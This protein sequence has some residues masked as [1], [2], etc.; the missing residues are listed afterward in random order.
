[1][2]FWDSAP[3]ANILP[4]LV[5]SGLIPSSVDTNDF[6][7]TPNYSN[8]KKPKSLLTGTKTLTR[9]TPNYQSKLSMQ[10]TTA[11]AKRS[12]DDIALASRRSLSSAT[13]VTLKPK[14]KPSPLTE[15]TQKNFQSNVVY[16]PPETESYYRKPAFKKAFC[17]KQ[18]S[19]EMLSNYDSMIDNIMKNEGDENDPRF[20]F[21]REN[22]KINATLYSFDTAIK[23]VKTYNGDIAMLLYKIKTFFQEMC[24]LVPEIFSLV[25]KE[26]ET[27]AN[28]NK[29]LSTTNANQET[30]INELMEIIKLKQQNEKDLTNNLNECKETI[31]KSEN[32]SKELE[33]QCSN[34]SQQLREFSF[35]LTKLNDEKQKLIEETR[36]KDKIIDQHVETIANHEE[37]IERYEEEGAAFKPLYDKAV[38]EMLV[39]KKNYDDLMDKY[40]IATKVIPKAD[41]ETEPMYTIEQQFKFM[42]K[43]KGKLNKKLLSNVNSASSINHSTL[44]LADTEEEDSKDSLKLAGQDS[45]QNSQVDLVEP[46]KEEA[47]EPEKV[48]PPPKEEDVHEVVIKEVQA[49]DAKNKAEIL[50][51]GYVLTNEIDNSQSLVLY[52]DKLLS[53]PRIVNHD[54]DYGIIKKTR[55][56]DLKSFSY[57][58]RQVIMIFKGGFVAEDTDKTKTFD[59][60]VQQVLLSQC[61]HKRIVDKVINDLEFSIAS[62]A[63]KSQAMQ[64]FIKFSQS[65]YTMHDF[66]FF[67][68]LFNMLYRK[69]YPSIEE[70]IDDPDLLC[71]KDL[72]LI[73]ISYADIVAKQILRRDF[74]KEAKAR[75]LNSAPNQGIPNM[76]PFWQLC[77]ELLKEFDDAHENYQQTLKSVLSAVG[78]ANGQYILRENFI[79]FMRIVK[80]LDSEKITNTMWENA[81]VT[82]SSDMHDSITM[83]EF[84]KFCGETH[85]LAAMI[86]EVPCH[87]LLINML[88]D[89][90]GPMLDLYT[91]IR[92]RYCTF[93]PKLLLTLP[94]EIKKNISGPVIKIRN[95][96]VNADLSSMF[97]YYQRI[98]LM[99][100][101]K[102]TELNPIIK[103]FKSVSRDDINRIQNIIMMRESIA[104]NHVN[105][106]EYDAKELIRDAR[107]LNSTT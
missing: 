69:V 61:Q 41:A 28:S 70:V 36:R 13:S 58:L 62:H 102:C 95:G 30:K 67:V 74:S 12:Y 26:K 48:E 79:D 55:N 18:E 96:L 87:P 103:I 24:K 107:K 92:K 8:L 75:L 11:K 106:E 44:N 88:N 16:L 80:P 90:T 57:T 7:K 94:E 32:Y 33:Y 60:I 25:E 77:I 86:F 3:A 15:D 27:L 52:V 101:I 47:N 56:G 31:N 51:Q 39:V 73:H 1:M 64:L 29:E 40:Q 78:W 46:Q 76:V 5:N 66:R 45:T 43:K 4:G 22:L 50:P 98:L 89:F 105:T 59:E 63:D 14:Y 35:R 83:Q 91:F 84:R 23:Q 19:Q 34:F 10:C 42:K 17:T 85:H 71:E 93:I 99:I 53:V 97:I 68:M 9:V 37:T 82:A 54:I 72:F 100:D 81:T 104:A 2:S 65:E 38:Q 21:E 6:V 49:V 20:L